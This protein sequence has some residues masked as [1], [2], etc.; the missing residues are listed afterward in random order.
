MMTAFG[1]PRGNVVD[2]F[3]AVHQHDH[4]EKQQAKREVIE[5]WIFHDIPSRSC[6]ACLKQYL[7]R[8]AEFI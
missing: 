6:F 4:D 8:S 3:D 1:D 7:P 5:E 2:R